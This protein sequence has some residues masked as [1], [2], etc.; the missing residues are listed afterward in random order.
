VKLKPDKASINRSRAKCKARTK[1]GKTCQAPPVDRGLCFFH[2]HPE[3]AAE[4]GRSGGRGNRRWKETDAGLPQLDLKSIGNV[5]EL[6]AE[7]IHRV[8][9]GPFDLRAATTTGYLAGMLLKVIETEEIEERLAR[10]EK[11]ADLERN[12]TIDIYKPLWLR[13]RERELLEAVEKRYLMPRPTP[14][15]DQLTEADATLYLQ[16]AG[17]DK[18]RARKMASLD[19]WKF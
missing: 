10:Q 4:L 11:A 18:D 14:G 3:K 1:A 17:G 7:T 5:R 15:N 13:E 9:Q 8:R 12:P 19:G 6:L 16:L 2:A